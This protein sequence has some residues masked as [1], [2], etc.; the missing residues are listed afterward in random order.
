MLTSVLAADLT[1]TR[2][3]LLQQACVANMKQWGLAFDLYSQDYNG[4]FFYDAEL[5]FNESGSPLERYFGSIGS[6]HTKIRTMRVCPAVAAAGTADLYRAWSYEMPIGIIHAGRGYQ[7]AL[8]PGGPYTD[9]N[10]N[11]WPSLKFCRNPSK[12]LMLIDCNGY[13]LFCGGLVSAV[14]TPHVGAGA[15]PVPA[16]NRHGGAVNCLFGDFHVELISA[17]TIS[18]Q[19]AIGCNSSNLWFMLN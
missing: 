1:Q 14:S 11:Y 5:H 17:Q 8:G 10:G 9:S 4:T 18:N 16:I 12:Y 3:K 2:M 13:A 19:D 7:S 15:D 6:N